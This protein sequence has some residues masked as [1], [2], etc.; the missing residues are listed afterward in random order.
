MAQDEYRDYMGNRRTRQPP[1]KGTGD[2]DPTDPNER[3]R[4][5]EAMNMPVTPPPEMPEK[6]QLDM[7]MDA[8]EK[9]PGGTIA[10]IMQ[11]AVGSL[12][13]RFNPN[14]PP[15]IGQDAANQ[16]TLG[17]YGKPPDMPPVPAEAQ[18]QPFDRGQGPGVEVSRPN[19]FETPQQP[20]TQRRNQDIMLHNEKDLDRLPRHLRQFVGGN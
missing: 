12:G 17:E 3:S 16:I 13:D 19:A 2:F 18:V 1:L 4:R 10:A 5:A 8:Y 15:S 7:L 11:S 6:S 20:G 14:A 9:D